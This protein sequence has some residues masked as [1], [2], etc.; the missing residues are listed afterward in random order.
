M[1]APLEK[2]LL[3]LHPRTNFAAAL[4]SAPDVLIRAVRPTALDAC[5]KQQWAGS[6]VLFLVVVFKYS[7][8]F[9]QKM[10]RERFHADNS[11][12]PLEGR[13]QSMLHVVT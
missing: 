10:A 3:F 4:V 6:Q 12:H 11:C 7:T 2:P 8:C 1:D 13:E 5:V 9:S